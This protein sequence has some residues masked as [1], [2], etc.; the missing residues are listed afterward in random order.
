[1]KHMLPKKNSLSRLSKSSWIFQTES[2]KEEKSIEICNMLST[3][4][5][6]YHYLDFAGK[7]CSK[8]TSETIFFL[9]LIKHSYHKLILTGK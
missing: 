7:I 4:W 8:I 3:A 6:N 9:A 1:M 2:Q 5:S